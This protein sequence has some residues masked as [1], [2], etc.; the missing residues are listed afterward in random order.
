MKKVLL[1]ANANSVWTK[2]YV[3]NIHYK[4]N[5]KVYITDYYGLNDDEKQFY[6]NLNVEIIDLFTDI[7]L[8][9]FI[10]YFVEFKKFAKEHRDEIDIVDIQS[11]PHSIQ[12]YLIHKTIKKL[13][14][15]SIITFWG[16][17]ILRINSRDAK[18]MQKL[19]KQATWINIG[20][21][22]MFEV[23]KKY[24]DDS[25]NDKCT[26]VEFGSPAL[27]YIK[28]CPLTKTECKKI[29]GLNSEKITVAVGY[30]GGKAQQ[31][32]LA[33]QALSE[34]KDDLKNK[35]QLMLHVGYNTNSEYNKEIEAA[36]QKSNFDYVMLKEMLNLE[37]I[38]K[39]RLATDIFV[40]A[41]TTD[42]LSGSIREAVY[43]GAILLNP[44]WLKYDKFD[45]DGV[46]YIKYADF[47]QLP[48][49]ITDV[50]EGNISIDK[51]KNKEILDNEY[52]WKSV[53]HKWKR[54]FDD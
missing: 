35:I 30:N 1:I 4:F 29:F 15:K 11:P 34:L 28:D 22:H 21:D 45:N 47:Q 37:E 53:E 50:L 25:Y 40:H 17:D 5:N 44:E 32:L 27:S 8:F 52:S 12:T 41:Q 49:K 26:F 16:S 20:T 42:G 46:E 31:H 10:K 38:A 3:K 24:Y 2:E 13:N 23:F 6:K 7:K 43:S 18:S 54:M 33:I 19:I 36:L 9:K 39:L 14:A 51:C 48:S